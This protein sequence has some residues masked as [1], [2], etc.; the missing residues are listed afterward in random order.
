MQLIL[1]LQQRGVLVLR[2]CGYETG[3]GI[4]I[5]EIGQDI[6][7]LDMHIAVMNQHRQKTAR[8]D[9]EKKLVEIFV[10]HQIDLVGFPFDPLEV[11]K[12]PKLLRAGRK[13]EMEDVES[14]PVEYFTR[15]DIFVG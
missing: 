13:R 2:P 3:L 12:N 9:A 1:M 5:F 14:L 6:V 4:H 8:I 10:G 7:A 15:L 11:Q